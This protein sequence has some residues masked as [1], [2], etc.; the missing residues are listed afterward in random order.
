MADFPGR[1]NFGADFTSL[2]KFALSQLSV[3]G[4]VYSINQKNRSRNRFLT[5]ARYVLFRF[6]FRVRVYLERHKNII[7]DSTIVDSRREKKVSRFLLLC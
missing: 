6:S 3:L 2:S 1:Y 4:E 7:V 5:F